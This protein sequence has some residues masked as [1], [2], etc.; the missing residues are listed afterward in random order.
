MVLSKIKKWQYPVIAKSSGDSKDKK[1]ITAKLY[2][3]ALLSAKNGFHPVSINNLVHTGVHFDKDALVELGITKPIKTKVNCIADGEVIAYRVNGHYQKIDYDEKVAFFSTGFVL[4]RHLLEMERVPEK[5]AETTE[6][7]PPADNNS[8]PSQ[9]PN[10]DTNSASNP[11]PAIAE[12]TPNQSPATNAETSPATTPAP[13]P[14]ETTENEKKEP[15]H[16]LYFY[17]LYMHLADSAYY[18]KYPDEPAPA[19]WE[20][21]IYRVIDKQLQNIV[22]LRIREKA[23]SSSSSSIKAVLQKGTK[24][25]LNLNLHDDNNKWYAVT[26]LVDGYTSIPTLTPFEYKNGNNIEKILGWV[27]TGKAVEQSEF[28]IQGEDSNLAKSKGLA[29]N[30]ENGKNVI[31]TLPIGTQIKIT[32]TKNENGL[33]ELTEIIRDGKPTIPLPEAKKMVNLAC[34]KKISRGKKYDEVVVLDTPF[35]IKAGDLV[36]HIGNYHDDENAAKKG[37]DKEG[38]PQ[39]IE[40]LPDDTFK[41]TY[42]NPLLHVE[43][44]TCEDLTNY[45]TQTQTEAGKLNDADKTFLAISKGAKLLAT[46]NKGDTTVGKSLVEDESIR[47]SSKN[48]NVNWLQI[49]VP[50]SKTISKVKE[51]NVPT[52]Q[53]KT[54]WI[55]NNKNIIKKAVLGGKIS[56]NAKTEAWTQHPLQIA[57]LPESP[58]IIDTPLLL[59]IYDK[60]YLAEDK[61][62]QDEHGN[63]WWKVEALDSRNRPIVGWVSSKDVGVKKVSVWDWFDFS[64]LTE[65]ASLVEFYKDVE[66]SEKRNK[67]NPS[68]DKYQLTLKTT[69]SILDRQY[70]TDSP[71]NKKYAYIKDKCFEGIKEKP[72]LFEALGR[73]LVNYKSEWYSEINTEGKMPD[74]EALNSVMTEDAEN[75]LGYL[76][77]GDEAKRDAHLKN[78]G[79]TADSEEAAGLQERRDK[80]SQFPADYKQNPKEKLNPAQLEQYYYMQKLETDVANWEK[81]K[82]KIKQCLWWDD[83]VKGLAN[84][85]QSTTDSGAIS[86]NESTPSTPT[87]QTEPEAP[88]PATLN[89]NGKAWFIHPISII[90]YFSAKTYLFEKGD[91][92]EIIR[93]INIRLAGF[94]GNVPT[95]EFTDR[96][97]KM[98]KQFQRDYMKVEETGIVDMKVIE[99]IDKFQKEH[100]IETYFEQAKCQCSTL[101]LVKGDKACGGFG[102]ERHSEEKQKKDPIEMYRK[103]EYPGLHR[104][105]FWVL[106]AWKFYLKHFDQ[107][108]MEIELVESGYRCWSN[109]RARNRSTTN[110]MGKALDIHMV[111]NNPKI[112]VANLCDDAR[113]VMIKYCNAYYRWYVKNVISLEAGNRVKI[114]TDKAIASTWVHFDVRSFELDYLKDEYFA[115]SVEQVNGLSMRSL[116]ANKD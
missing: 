27:Y 66:L 65:N 16:Q 40:I 22:G 30:D 53:T 43:C 20:Q 26:S 67:D 90:N 50:I 87:E 108:N 12:V 25:N 73:L 59:N 29:V 71:E 11:S 106:R 85:N 52:I 91:K 1:D 81:E 76:R 44:F 110:H 63:L 99:A 2:Y 8:T 111:Y 86:E 38:K 41:D 92:H 18:D 84:Q 51:K 10:A 88:P 94:G 102:L 17:S 107:R 97:E 35:P 21:D 112:T 115:K 49:Q 15:G 60:Q 62:A 42:F 7:T 77:D 58:Q 75:V 33:V 3:K 70:P 61:F 57:N 23:K 113:E 80:I 101:K 5:K 55:A 98:I 72:I 96:T 56:L 100:P 104:T 105:L 32:G 69:L 13:T 95:D 114:S 64:R 47:V 74:R 93:E 37:K 9:A 89:P 109:N 78:I 4:V 34:L 83:V 54:L 24:I 48:V 68:L 28:E 6:S 31:S 39:D 46:P 82:E 14:S 45:I 116:I 103:Y 79:K 19:F 36:G